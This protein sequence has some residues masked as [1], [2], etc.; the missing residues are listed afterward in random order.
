MLT[1]E[2]LREVL[3]YDAETGHFSIG[4]R[5]RR[6]GYVVV[7]IDGARYLAHRLAWL[8]VTGEWPS[9]LIDHIDRDRANNRI[10]NLRDVSQ[11]VNQQNIVSA[12]RNS[13]SG[14][15]GAALCKQ[16]GRWAARIRIHGV[17]VHLGR[18]DTAELAH[19]AYIAAKRQFHEGNTL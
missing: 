14:L 1:V 10:T 17:K 2:R 12:K 8:Y 13:R 18:F 5:P 6:D 19:A 7:R 16:T 11:S 4:E 9:G 3:S 15:L